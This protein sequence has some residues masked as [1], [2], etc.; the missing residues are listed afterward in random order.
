MDIKKAFQKALYTLAFLGLLTTAN[1]QN[2]VSGRVQTVHPDTSAGHAGIT[3]KKDGLTKYVESDSLDGTFS[4]N[5]P[6]GTYNL[7]VKV[8]DAYIIEKSVDITSNTNMLIQPINY[9]SVKYEYSMF[10]GLFDNNLQ[11]LWMITETHPA[12]DNHIL[13]RW[14]DKDLPLK[15]YFESMPEWVKSDMNTVVN[16]IANKTVKNKI[17]EVSKS[18]AKAKW[19][20]VTHTPNYKPAETTVFGNYQNNIYIVDSSITYVDTSSGFIAINTIG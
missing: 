3:F 9:D 19:F 17:V 20:F 5:L 15:T 16:N 14:S 1:A 18:Q 11:E 12:L 6:S 7:T 8:K 13:N 2:T 10:P 4:T